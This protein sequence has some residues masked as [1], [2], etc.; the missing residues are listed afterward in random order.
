[1]IT[2]IKLIDGLGNQIF[3]YA[4]VRHLAVLNKTEIK[5]DASYFKKGP[6]ENTALV[7]SITKKIAAD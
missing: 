6:I 5:F 1:M 4:M 2:V 3:Q 7:T